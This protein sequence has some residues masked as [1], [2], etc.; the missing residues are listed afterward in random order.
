MQQ[1]IFNQVLQ[2]LKEENTMCSNTMLDILNC[3]MYNIETIIVDKE[4][5]I[6]HFG[7]NPNGLTVPVFY[8]EYLIAFVEKKLGYKRILQPI[9]KM[10][11]TWYAIVKTWLVK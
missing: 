3:K 5:N 8:Y 6:F 9:G 1:G 10:D 4:N 11:Q 7:F 2:L